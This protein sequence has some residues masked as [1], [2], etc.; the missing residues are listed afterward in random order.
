LKALASDVKKAKLSDGIARQRTVAHVICYRGDKC[1]M[2]FPIYNDDSIV[3]DEVR[4]W[5]KWPQGLQS[6]RL[7]TPH[8]H[9]IELRVKCAANLK[10]LWYR[11]RLYEKVIKPPPWYTFW[12]SKKPYPAPNKWCDS[13][14]HAHRVAGMIEKYPYICPSAGQGKCHY[15]MNPNCKPDSPR[16]MVLLFETR[17]GWDQHGGPELFTFDNHDPRGGCVLLNNG[18]V[19]FIRNTEEFQKLRWK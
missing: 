13:T 14:F 10:H 5:I 17:A 15:A 6:L 19:K 9:S 16:D 18:T 3:I 7:L 1:L 8:V 11:F 12:R 4:Y 2:S